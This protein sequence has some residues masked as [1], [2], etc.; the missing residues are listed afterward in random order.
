MEDIL[1]FFEG[2]SKFAIPF[3]MISAVATIGGIAY[4]YGNKKIMLREFKKAEKSQLI[5]FKK[6]SMPKLL[7]KQNT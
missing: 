4:Y 3:L 6:M 1:L 5:E 2:N 7:E